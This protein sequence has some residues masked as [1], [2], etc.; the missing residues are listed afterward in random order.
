[1]EN[2]RRFLVN[3]GSKVR[4]ITDCETKRKKKERIGKIVATTENFVVVKYARGYR[5]CF[6]LA[7]VIAPAG[8]KILAWNGS[9][10]RDVKYERNDELDS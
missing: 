6:G 4:V 5:E 1:M 3:I 2:M 9:E 7:D 8:L 10:W